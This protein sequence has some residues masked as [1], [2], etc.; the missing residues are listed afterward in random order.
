MYLQLVYQIENFIENDR[1]HR[2]HR[3]PRIL[4]VQKI[5][6]NH[7]NRKNYTNQRNQRKRRNLRIP[8]RGVYVRE[9]YTIMLRESIACVEEI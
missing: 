5:R 2:N 1:N 7:R 8:R 3:N 4:E 9:E 6:R